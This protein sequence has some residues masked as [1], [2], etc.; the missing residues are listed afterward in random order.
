M[1]LPGWNS[2]QATG[3]LAS[4]FFWV[5]MGALV[6]VGFAQIISYGYGQ[7]HDVLESQQENAE[8]HTTDK[9]IAR[10]HRQAATLEATVERS[11]LATAGANTRAQEAQQ[12]LAGANARAEEAQLALQQLKAPRSLT[13]DAARAL[14][15]ALKP[16]EGQPWT[17]TTFWDLKEPLDFATML[18]EP[19]N[20][21]GW[22]YDNSG[23]KRLL[24]DGLS[25][26]QVLVHPQ[27]DMK[28]KAAAMA[29]VAALNR[30]NFNAAFKLESI[31]D[32][33]KV[34]INVG[35]KVDP[36]S[37]GIAQN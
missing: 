25:G 6:L 35:S 18:Y 19:L 14:K 29:L 1:E 33:D 17:M 21:A 13:D 34:Q 24:P 4:A 16:F 15:V 7:R 31:V 2:L 10:L 28:V 37:L 22:K 27:A 8:R 9:Q 26:V 36:S 32:I 11:Q 20:G 23:S 5:S 3:A 12:A 30:H